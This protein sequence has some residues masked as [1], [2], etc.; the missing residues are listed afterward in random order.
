MCHCTLEDKPTAVI[1]SDTGILLLMVHVFASHLPDHDWFL[2][3]KK[4]QFVNVSKIHE[5]IGN[6]AAITLPAMFVLTGCDTVTYFYVSPRK[7][8]LSLEARSILSDF[9][10]HTSLS[11]MSKEKRK[12][13]VQ[14]FVYS[15]YVLMY[16]LIF[17]L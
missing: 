11:K 14:I 8:Y 15:M 6:S 4:N 12:R 9:G 16:A 13:F 17:Y 5:Y 10:E 2:Q 7:P 1:A 3:T